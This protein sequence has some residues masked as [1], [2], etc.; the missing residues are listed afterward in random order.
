MP[1][2][3]ETLSLHQLPALR[4]QLRAQRAALPA[5]QQ[6]QHAHQAA[7]HLQQAIGH[8]HTPRRLALYSASNGELNTVP[9]QTLLANEADIYWPVITGQSLCFGLLQSQREGQ[10]QASP[11]TANR[12]GIAEP[13]LAAPQLLPASQLDIIVV[14]LVAFDGYGNR[15]GMGGGFYDRSLTNCR[16]YSPLLIGYGHSFQQVNQLPVQPWDK[17]LH[18]V[19]TESDCQWFSKPAFS[20]R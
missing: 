17:K 11:L 12:F 14:P 9:L 8:S 20:R 13:D 4:H 18:A 3:S 7:R 1:N 10:L 15:L 6:Q 5:Q 19:V 16:D 2:H